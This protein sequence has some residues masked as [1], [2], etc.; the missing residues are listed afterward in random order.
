MTLSFTGQEIGIK[1]GA[2]VWRFGKRVTN[3]LWFDDSH[4]C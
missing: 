2:L 3:L 1:H 4:S